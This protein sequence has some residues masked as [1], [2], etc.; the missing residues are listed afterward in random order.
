LAAG[1]IEAKAMIEPEAKAFLV[2]VAEK[3]SLSAR[4]FHRILRVARTIADLGG[5][6]TVQRGHIA[7]TLSYRRG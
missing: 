2:M 7:E 4:S 6:D 1:E 3:L 5:V